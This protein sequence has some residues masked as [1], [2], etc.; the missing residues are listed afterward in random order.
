M[1]G[2]RSQDE[3]QGDDPLLTVDERDPA[4]YFPGRQD[5]SDEVAAPIGLRG[6]RTDVAQ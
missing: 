4:A 6:N 5:R 2:D 1:V 3:H